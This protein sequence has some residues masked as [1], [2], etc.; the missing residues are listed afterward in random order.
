MYSNAEKKVLFCVVSKKEMV[1]VIDIAKKQDPNAFV[2]ISD[3]REVMGE[4]F[5]SLDG[6]REK[7]S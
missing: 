5:L 3:V 1:Q 2:I 7:N 6:G 4:G